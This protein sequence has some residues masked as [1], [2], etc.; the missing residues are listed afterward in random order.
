MIED[1][2]SETI[3]VGD[4]DPAQWNEYANDRG[5]S[6][7]FPLAVPTQEAVDRFLQTCRKDNAPFAPMSPRLLVPTMPAIAANAVMAGCRAEYFPVVVAA[8]RGSR[9]RL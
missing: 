7:G 9:P 2:D 8:V 6:D 5:W 1:M 4:L 3:E